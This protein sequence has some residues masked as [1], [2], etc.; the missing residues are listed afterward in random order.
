MILLTGLNV[1]TV[2]MP[3]R[4][5]EVMHRWIVYKAKQKEKRKKRRYSILELKIFL[6][7]TL[8]KFVHT[9]YFGQ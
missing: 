6:F 7:L 2:H 8:Y 3:R 4:I 1:W 5:Y 9:T